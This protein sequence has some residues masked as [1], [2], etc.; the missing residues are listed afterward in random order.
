VLGGHG[1][2]L[3]AQWLQAAADLQKHG[4]GQ[5]ACCCLLLG[6]QL[7]AQ[8]HQVPDAHAKLRPQQ[9]G[10]RHLHGIWFKRRPLRWQGASQLV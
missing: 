4:V 10:A 3:E 1:W 8:L 7:A 6:W 5:V 9:D 2:Q